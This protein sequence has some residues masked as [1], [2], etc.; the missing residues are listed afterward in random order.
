MSRAHTHQLTQLAVGEQVLPEV[1]A[2][3]RVQCLQAV[4]QSNIMLPGATKATMPPSVLVRSRI[5]HGDADGRRH[6]IKPLESLC[7]H[8]FVPAIASELRM[9]L[10]SLVV[11]R[12]GR[13]RDYETDPGVIDEEL[14]LEIS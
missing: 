9:V 2:V 10:C 11:R 7:R 12:H 13:V 5:V 14:H 6:R 4:Q 3:S 8:A 1:H